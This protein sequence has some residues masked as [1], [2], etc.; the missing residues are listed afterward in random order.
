MKFNLNK[1][2]PRCNAKMAATIAVCPNCSLN[3]N[4]FYE[5]TNAEAKQAIRRGDKDQVLLR[6]GRPSDVKFVPL[7][8]T[9]IFLGLFGGHHYKVGRYK[10]G[11]FYSIFFIVGIANAVLTSIYKTQLTG[12]M[13]EIFSLL[14]IVWGAVILMWSIDLA[15]ICLNKYKIPVSRQK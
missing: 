11:I 9:A 3:F 2:C 10:M 4:K 15:K 6:T 13:W 8:L 14:V 1:K 12:V 5:A 7:L